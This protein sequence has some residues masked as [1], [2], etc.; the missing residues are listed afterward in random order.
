MLFYQSEDSAGKRETVQKDKKQENLR[1]Q[2]E[3]V[4]MLE[5]RHLFW[6]SEADNPELAKV[7]LEIATSLE[8]AKQQYDR[9]FE[10]FYLSTLLQDPG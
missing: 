7:H 4:Q 8:N 5:R 10:I 2:L 6:A 9:L 1:L 3:L